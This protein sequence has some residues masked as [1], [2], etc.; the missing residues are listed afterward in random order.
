MERKEKRTDGELKQTRVK[1]SSMAGM[2]AELGFGG[3][4]RGRE[5]RQ[6]NTV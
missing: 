6:S 4:R 1:K 2:L 5:E 3:G